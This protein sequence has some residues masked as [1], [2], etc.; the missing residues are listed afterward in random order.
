[1]FGPPVI[2]VGNKSY[3]DNFPKSELEQIVSLAKWLQQR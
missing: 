2:N 1:M 3:G